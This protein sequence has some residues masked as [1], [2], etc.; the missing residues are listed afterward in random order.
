[1]FFLY[2]GQNFANSCMG[3]NFIHMNG[4]IQFETQAHYQMIVKRTR[5]ENHMKWNRNT[6]G[7]KEFKE[8]TTFSEKAGIR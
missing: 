6:Y 2:L 3:S 8:Y 1:M 5:K 4:P 7:K